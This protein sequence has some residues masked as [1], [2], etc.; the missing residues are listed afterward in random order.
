MKAARPEDP[1]IHYHNLLPFPQ[2]QFNILQYRIELHY[3]QN[4]SFYFSLHIPAREH[5]TTSPTY[6]TPTS[7]PC[8][9]QLRRASVLDTFFF[10]YRIARLIPPAAHPQTSALKPPV[11]TCK[12]AEDSLPVSVGRRAPKPRAR[13]SARHAKERRQKLLN[14]AKRHTRKGGRPTIY[15]TII[16][17]SSSSESDSNS[18]RSTTSSS[19]AEEREDVR[20]LPLPPP[21]T[22][23]STQTSPTKPV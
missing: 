11:T 19:S 14:F 18:A 1:I 16:S 4:H 2:R 20:A 10:L 9:T 23:D 5:R 21:T 8:D 13:A 22:T 15:S 17:A 7:I 6:N 12:E 3:N